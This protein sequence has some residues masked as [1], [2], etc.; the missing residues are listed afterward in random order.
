MDSLERIV[1][2]SRRPS[3]FDLVGRRPDELI[4]E[5]NQPQLGRSNLMRGR[6]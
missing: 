3:A 5:F 2:R 4:A 6:G 1:G